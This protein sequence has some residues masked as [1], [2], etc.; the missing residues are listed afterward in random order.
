MRITN[1][2]DLPEPLVRAVTLRGDRERQPNT[3]SV[4]QLIQPPQIRGLILK[5]DNE[6]S[7]DSSDRI[8]ALMGQLMAQA[9][10][11]SAKD[12]DGHLA[13][14]QLELNVLGWKVTGRYDLSSV[15][16]DGEL[17]SDYKLTSVWALKDGVKPEFEQQLNL[18]KYLIETTTKRIISALEIVA[19]YRDWSKNKARYDKT[20][21]QKQ[22]EK[23]TVPLWSPEETK[24][25]LEERVRLHQ[26]AAEGKWPDCTPDEKWQRP[27]QFR[28][29]K[30]GQKR[31]VKLYE[32]RKLADLHVKNAP[33]LYVVERPGEAV[34]C[35]AYCPVRDVCSQRLR[36][37]TALGIIP[38]DAEAAQREN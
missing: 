35:E 14:E 29:E 8:W 38:H 2:F 17:L 13:E 11:K 34:R 30:Q 18:Y 25:F 24:D 31:A 33:A 7:E 36:E 9:L 19:I 27:T 16:L 15:V 26:D 4:T 20:Y 28:V 37:Q 3:I 21:T 22:V 1:Q 12:L 32:S 10:E 5:H 6:L 23:F